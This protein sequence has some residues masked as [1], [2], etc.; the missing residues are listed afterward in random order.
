MSLL[1]TFCIRY[2]Y[3]PN[4]MI[5][6]EFIPLV[7]DKGGHITDVIALANVETKLRNC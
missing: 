2:S 4:S 5:E 7:K 1:F 6:I 3:L